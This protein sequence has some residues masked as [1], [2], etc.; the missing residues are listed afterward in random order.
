[1]ARRTSLFRSVRSSIRNLTCRVVD[2]NI[3][4]ELTGFKRQH[5]VGRD[6]RWEN[7]F[8]AL[9]MRRCHIRQ[10]WSMGI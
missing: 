9:S 4:P 6:E 8:F 1:M 7:D 5:G 2:L 3:R 10:E